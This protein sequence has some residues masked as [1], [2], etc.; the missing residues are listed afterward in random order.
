MHNRLILVEGIPGSGKSTI[1]NR[2]KGYLEGKGV[3]VKLFNEGEPHPADLAWSA[4]LSKEEYERVLQDYS[5]YR[6]EIESSSIVEE[7]SAIVAY[8]KI[9]LSAKESELIR[10]LEAHEVYD[11]KVSLDTFKRIHLRRW[12]RF[13]QELDEN[14]V[15]IFECAYLQNHINEL[16]GFYKKDTEFIA[17]Y[18]VELIKTVETL[19]PKLIYLSQPDIRETIS[20][21]AKERV[22]NDKSKWDDWIDLVIRYVE[23]CHFG[24][25]HG[26]KGFDGVV[27]FFM[28]RKEVELAVID[29]LPVEK[30]IINNEKYDWEENFKQVLAALSF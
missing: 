12:Q 5:E 17:E 2:I 30:A 26:L 20:R 25:A 3:K 27:E 11:G 7:D 10:Y 18:M 14:S 6:S 16:M 4:Y 21:V 15:V 22:T 8:T 23:N 9:G 24:K 19:N 28:A 1:S 29:S 13:A